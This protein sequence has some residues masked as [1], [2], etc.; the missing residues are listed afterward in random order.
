MASNV[1][2]F[3][4]NYASFDVPAPKR[5]SK[6][7]AS[8]RMQ[9]PRTSLDHGKRSSTSTPSV[10]RS[11]SKTPPAKTTTNSMHSFASATYFALR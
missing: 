2:D 10:S 9:T 5:Y 1:T 3:T 8:S 7:T 11:N 6:S 4:I